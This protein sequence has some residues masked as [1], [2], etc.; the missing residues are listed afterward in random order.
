MVCVD[1]PIDFLYFFF[2]SRILTKYLA[3]TSEACF[4]QMFHPLFF[5]GEDKYNF[6]G[7]MVDFRKKVP[8]GL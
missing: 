8:I 4:L 1:L 2:F 5:N 6:V 3:H 7:T